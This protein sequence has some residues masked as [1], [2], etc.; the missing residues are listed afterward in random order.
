[1]VEVLSVLVSILILLIFVQMFLGMRRQIPDPTPNLLHL[2]GKID[3]LKTQQMQ[4]QH[5]WLTEQQDLLLKTQRELREQLESVQKTV[6]SNLQSTQGQL[7]L[8]LQESNQVIGQIQQ[9]LGSLEETTKNIKEIGKD[10]SSLQDLL[11]APKLRGNIGE[12]LLEQLLRDVLPEKQWKLQYQF[13]NRVQVDAVVFI[14]EKMV[15]I[16]SKFPLESFQRMMDAQT[17]TQEEKD[18]FKREFYQSIKNKI[19]DIASK[20]IQSDEG[21]YDFA[22]MYVPAEKVFYEFLTL[23]LSGERESIFNYAIRKHVIPVS[24]GTFYAYLMAIVLGLRGLRVEKRAMEILNHLSQLERTFD[25]FLSDYRTL[26]T[27]LTNA[28]SKYEESLKKAEG[29]QNNLINLVKSDTSN[30]VPV[31][32][33]R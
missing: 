1:M 2:L 14:G 20:Y 24:P 23:Q 9:K 28:R 16:D 17:E 7:N 32:P 4:T 11:R 25:S 31:L 19:N 5:Q 8:R 18:K 27:H 22:L 26:G 3:E 12:F 21:T 13:S 10:I 29:I 33:E 30:N 15:P 6:Q